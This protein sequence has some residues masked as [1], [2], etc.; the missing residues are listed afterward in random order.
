MQGYVLAQF[1]PGIA[2]A[3]GQGVPQDYLQAVHWY[4]LAAK[5]GYT[6]AQIAL[7][8]FYD[9]GLGVQ[10]DY[11]KA[12]MWLDLAAAGGGQFAAKERD[13]VAAHMT[14]AQIAKAQQKA[15]Q[16]RPR[17]AAP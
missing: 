3:H 2:Y 10:K 13:R 8:L 7:G 14:R 15:E 5:Q 9:S 16:F 4:S 17:P 12:Y 6:M 11:A 1:F